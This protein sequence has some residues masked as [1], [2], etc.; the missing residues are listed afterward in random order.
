MERG[1]AR[2][3]ELAHDDRER[4]QGAGKGGRAD[5]RDDHAAERR[6]PA[7]AEALRRLGQRVHVD[8]AEACV[9]RE[10][11]VREREHD[12]RG[13]EELRRGVEPV[14]RPAAVDVE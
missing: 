8:G 12:V 1:E 14:R 9:E 10:E 3:R 2:D 11:R 4:E 6:A 13:D 5:V 7:R